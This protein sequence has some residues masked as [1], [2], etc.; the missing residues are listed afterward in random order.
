MRSREVAKELTYT[1]EQHKR[2]VPLLWRALGG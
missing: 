1:D 2:L